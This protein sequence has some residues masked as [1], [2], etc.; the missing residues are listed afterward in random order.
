MSTIR[1][2]ILNPTALKLIEGMQDLNLIKVSVEPE[3]RL[4]AYLQK[5]RR[6]TVS[7]PDIDEITSIVEK[8]RA[9]RY[10]KK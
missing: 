9:E 7:A 2:E 8:V 10:G 3:S 5:M 6:N 1:I 4:K